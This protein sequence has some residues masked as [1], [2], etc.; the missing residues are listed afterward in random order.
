MPPPLSIS[1]KSFRQIGHVFHRIGPFPSSRTESQ[2]AAAAAATGN[3][4]T[5]AAA[6]TGSRSTVV[7]VEAGRRRQAPAAEA[8]EID[9]RLMAGGSLSTGG[10]GSCGGFCC[11]PLDHRCGGCSA[12]PLQGCSQRASGSSCRRAWPSVRSLPGR[13]GRALLTAFNIA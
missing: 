11:K 2:S 6:E 9:K 7:T 3:R 1:S 8:A 13:R 10:L 4:H 5:A 12:V